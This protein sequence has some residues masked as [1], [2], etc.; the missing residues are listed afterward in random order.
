MSLGIG[1]IGFGIAA[2][3]GGIYWLF[4]L[5][6]EMALI[7]RYKFGKVPE[8]W[9]I[10]VALPDLSISDVPHKRVS[11]FGYELELPW[12]DVDEQKERIV[13]TIHVTYFHSGNGFWF[14]I[15]SERVCKRNNEGRQA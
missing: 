11:Y 5:Q 13:N 10:P 8:V 9:K 12:D 1:R 2:V 4:G 14:Y 3:V 6:T 7:T 15:P